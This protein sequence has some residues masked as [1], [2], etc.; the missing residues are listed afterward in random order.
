MIGNN[1][2]VAPVLCEEV[3]DRD[4]YIPP[5]VWED[6]QLGNFILGPNMLKGYSVA[7]QGVIMFRRRKVI[8]ER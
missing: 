7:P 8:G 5:G 1:L 3:T 2:L 6:L 4:I